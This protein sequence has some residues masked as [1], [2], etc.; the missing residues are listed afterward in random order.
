MLK[1]VLEKEDTV[2]RPRVTMLVL[3]LLWIG[4]D[5]ALAATKI[6]HHHTRTAPVTLAALLD[7]QGAQASLGRP[8]MNGFVLGLQQGSENEPLLFSALI[9]TKSDPEAT[10]SA[11]RD[12]VSTSASLAAGF[13]DNNS[14]LIAG[15]FFH[16][17]PVPFLSI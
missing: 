6:E 3:A 4:F 2:Y 7:L 13:T 1:R 16:R 8:A 15:P 10:K 17:A 12:V 11:A 9:D 5:P 14:V